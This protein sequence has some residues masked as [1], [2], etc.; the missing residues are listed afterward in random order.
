M[1]VR[2][3]I[4]EDSYLVRAGIESLLALGEEVRVVASCGSV[5][6]LLRT[7][8]PGVLDLVLTDIRMPPGFSDEGIVLAN[9][10]RDSHP[11]LGV[12][13][14]SQYVEPHYAIALLERGSN[15]RGY[16]LKDRL[17]DR[18]QL[19]RAIEEVADDG[20]FVD[21]S[22]VEHLMAGTGSR[23]DGP[24]AALSARERDILA[25][26]AEGLSNA[27]I[28][29]RLYLS[30]RAVEKHINSVFAKLGLGPD[31][32]AVSR[33]VAAALVYLGRV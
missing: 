28:A 8:D 13:V 21:P 19:V 26:V 15:G 10:L 11:D 29:D 4:A 27:S 22:V 33:R 5:E 18:A 23:D 3:A 6:E 2:I 31:D 20:S 7:T 9:G 17:H 30:K 24:L 14:V 16:L 1:A 25:L 12:L 32:T